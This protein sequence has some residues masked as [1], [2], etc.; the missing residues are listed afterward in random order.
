M[1]VCWHQQ[2]CLLTGASGGIGS[3]IAH[4]LATLGVR[5]ILVGRNIQKL[6]E[7][8]NQLPGQHRIISANIGNSADRDRI[9]GICQE[10]GMTML[11]NNAGISAVGDFHGMCEEDVLALVSTNLMAPMALTHRLL[12]LLRKVEAGIVV[13][14]GSAFG[15]IG[16]PCHAAYCASKFGLRGWT[17]SLIREYSQTS[18][19]FY[20]LAPRATNTAINAQ[21]V[22]AMNNALGNKMDPPEVV[23][24]ALVAQINQN[25]KRWFI[26]SP[27]KWFAR[28]NGALPELV[29][30]ALIKKLKT[31]RK[32]V[33][34]VKEESLL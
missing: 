34:S 4:K 17:E 15:S 8:V 14:V 22:V 9:F 29:D 19:S 30:N 6:S 24:E 16:F 5:L 12:P 27:E 32:Y 28:I 23:A 3:A 10:T 18:L 2:V 11:V 33:G 20:Y 31:I 21:N 13:N 26:G 7:L 1:S 25:R